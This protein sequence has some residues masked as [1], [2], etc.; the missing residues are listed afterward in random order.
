MFLVKRVNFNKINII[1]GFITALFFSAF[2]YLAYFNIEHKILD[3][4]LALISLYLLLKVNKQTLFFAGFFVGILWFYWIAISFEY[5]NLSY[6]SPLIILSLGLCYGV[7]FYL[8]ALYDHPIFRILIISLLS[9]INPFGFNWFI[10]ELIF[11][12][13]YFPT[14]K[15]YFVLILALIFMFISLNNKLKVLA[16]IPLIFIYENN[17]ITINNPNIQ[18][19]MP[20]LNITQDSKWLKDNQKNIINENFELINN[21]IENNKDLIV[22]PETVFPVLLNKETFL[23][24]KLQEKSKK[25]DILLGSLYLEN[26]QFYNAT[27]HF[28]NT[29]VNIAK[30]V[31]LVPF[32]EEIPLPKFFVNLINDIF[33]NGGQDYQKAK[34]ATDFEIKGTKFRNAICYEATSEKIYENLGEVKYMIAT[35]NNAWF[36]PSIEPTL[37]KL[38]LKYYSKKYDITILH[39]VNG[40]DN[41]IIY[42]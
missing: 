2:I 6:L 35:S 37:Q 40:S 7:L 38:I 34:K 4:I 9:F 17:G 28:S 18:I 22:L 5:Y 30:K 27:Y 11:I 23:M 36:T 32:G 16:F 42:P 20:Q 29:Q 12:N 3:T 26:N 31:V 19:S 8:V 39:S 33:Y 24:N 15:E 41:Y 1:K 21:A 25:I 10:P 13:S 14:S